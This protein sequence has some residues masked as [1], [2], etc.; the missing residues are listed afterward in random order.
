M[1]LAKADAFVRRAPDDLAALIHADFVYVNAGGRAFGKAG[2]IETYCTSGTILF[3]SRQVSDLRVTP[4]DGFAV[5]TM[6]LADSL[7]ADG[8]VVTGRFHSLCVFSVVRDAG[9]GRLAKR[10]HDGSVLV[11]APAIAMFG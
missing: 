3:L 5:A 11:L 1:L 2:Y 8:Q 9:S 10:W 4:F 6:V 7:Q